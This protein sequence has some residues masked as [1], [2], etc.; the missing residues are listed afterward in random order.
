MKIEKH[1][2]LAHSYVDQQLQKYWSGEI[3]RTECAVRVCREAHKN[4]N[5]IFEK[6][7]I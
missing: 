1:E 3:T 7:E 5:S 4:V 6:N 2:I